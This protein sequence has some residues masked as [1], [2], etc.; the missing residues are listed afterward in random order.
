MKIRFSPLKI[1]IWIL[2]TLVL[3]EG[4]FIVVLLKPRKISPLLPAPRGKIAIVLDDWGYNLNNLHILDEIKLP[5]TCAV[6]PNLPYS[7]QIAQALHQRGCE[8]IL[9]LPMEPYE[10][11]RLEKNT[12]QIS[13]DKETIKNIIEQDLSN[14]TH[15][16]GVSNHMGS[17]ATSDLRVME[18]IFAELK[19]RHLYFLDSLVS[20]KSLCFELAKKMNL[21]FA[22]R[23][24]FLD[25]TPER[26]YIKKQL[27]KLKQKA[28]IKGYALGIGHDRK[29]TLE[30]LREM[31][32]QI[33]KE[34][35]QF[36]FV[37]EVVE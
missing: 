20:S 2:A 6:L 29:L 35:Y 5:L 32:P 7:R 27:E 36:V 14:I 22:R 33:E 16:Q 31:L 24:V 10:E 4:M 37:S 11:Y 30:T 9:H 13:M 26:E 23:D 15:P 8:I 12:I 28:Q 1:A 18:I 17:R 25:N 3:I 34:G 19:K 21:K